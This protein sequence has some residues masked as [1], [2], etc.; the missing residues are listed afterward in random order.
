MRCFLSMN[1]RCCPCIT[2]TRNS[3]M[4]WPSSVSSRICRAMSKFRM[5]RYVTFR[6]GS[7]RLGS[8]SLLLDASSSGVGISPQKSESSSEKPYLMSCLAASSLWWTLTPLVS[9]FH[10]VDEELRDG[11]AIFGQGFYAACDCHS[12]CKS[13]SGS[14]GLT[15][16]YKVS[17][18]LSPLTLAL[19]PRGE[20]TSMCRTT[21]LF[22]LNLCC[23]CYARM[24]GLS[25]GISDRI[26]VFSLSP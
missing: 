21:R 11:V 3:I 4:R 18:D 17:W 2:L 24:F 12:V 25:R 16:I 14:V 6:L 23:L 1:G 13:F 5:S 26:S 9:S 19:S 15:W 7:S 22:V 10:R 8:M 20:G